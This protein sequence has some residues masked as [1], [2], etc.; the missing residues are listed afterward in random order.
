MSTR[1]TSP[2]RYDGRSRTAPSW[3]S[4]WPRSAPTRPVES[5]DR[6]TTTDDR[7]PGATNPTATGCPVLPRPFTGMHQWVPVHT[8]VSMWDDLRHGSPVYEAAEGWGYA[9][10][11]ID[12][13]RDALKDPELFSNA[14]IV[15]T[16][17]DPE[18]RWIP[19]M[20][21]PPEHTAWRQLLAPLFSPT[22]MAQLED[23]VRA[24]C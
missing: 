15:P 3:R 6:V 20:L 7:A 1:R 11:R 22:A 2:I 12:A 21:D 17:P 9:F 19:E 24:R 16:D 13:I 23:T 10:T 14:S 4:R 8:Y 18:Y 5:E